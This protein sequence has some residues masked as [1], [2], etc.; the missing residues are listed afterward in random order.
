MSK[1]DIIKFEDFKSLNEANIYD[2]DGIPVE[3]LRMIAQKNE[4]DARGSGV[5]PRDVMP[6]AMELQRMQR[7]QEDQLE[8]IAVDT[9]KELYGDILNNVEIDAKIVRD[10]KQSIQ[11]ACEDEEDDK[12]PDEVEEDDI[13]D[14]KGEIDKRKILNS[15][16]Q[17]EAKNIHRIIHMEDVK[18]KLDAL[19]P[20]YVPL[21]DNLLKSNEFT[22]WMIPEEAAVQMMENQ[23]NGMNVISWKPVE[24][25]E[26]EKEEESD[27]DLAQ[28]ILDDLENGDDML[29][30][31]EDLEELFDNGQPKII[32]RAVDFPILMHEI[33]KG[34]FELIVA[35][36]IPEDANTASRIMRETD[37]SLDEFTDLRYGVDMRRDYTDYVVKRMD[38]VGKEK[39]TLDT[40]KNLKEYVFGALLDPKNV[41]TKNFLVLTNVIFSTYVDGL[42]IDPTHLKKAN[43]IIDDAIKYV[44]DK[45]D[46]ERAEWDEYYNE[47]EEWE[48]DQEEMVEQGED[49]KVDTFAEVQEVEKE[50]SQI[51]DLKQQM[52]IAIDDEDYEEAA[53][54]RDLIETL[55]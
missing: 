25:E 14:I 45:L 20:R 36:A 49:S 15:I 53:R 21:M 32:A 19:N 29:D 47:L 31:S 38:E 24:K 48:K 6:L 55:K 37:S 52:K 1:K 42:E 35:V 18:D 27:E 17:G 4:S 28:R 22:E 41:S 33:T 34:I 54:L 7:G 8:V 23:P 2:N 16:T 50:L 12:E 9:I 30:H 11:D 51:D 5:N 26:E 3:Y 39:R 44:V 10:V 40:H 46:A 13:S 43:S